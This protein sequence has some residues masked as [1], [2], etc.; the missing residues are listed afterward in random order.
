MASATAAPEPQTFDEWYVRSAYQDFVRQ[1]G[2]PLY[3]GSAIA[4][5]ASIELAPWQRRGG[6]VAY[7][8]LGEQEQRNLQIVEIPP[9][10]SLQPEHHMYD[11]VMYVM[12]GRG[13]TNIW[14]EGEPKR[15]IEWQEGS[16][17][18]LPL[19]AWHQEFNGSGSEPCRFLIASNMAY[20]INLYNNLEFVFNTPFQFKDRYSYDMEQY[21]AR[22]KKW[23]FRTLESNFIPD[24]RTMELDPYLERGRRTSVVRISMAAT[25]IGMHVME[26]GEGTYVTA[27]RHD[28]QAHVIVIGGEGYELMFMEGEEPRKV[29]AKPY[30]VVA[31]RHNEFHQH[32]NSGH[33]GYRML[34]FRGMGLRYGWGRKHELARG[35]QS[36][37]RNAVLYNIPAD[38]EDPAIREDYY[39]ELEKKGIS[40]RLEPLSQSSRG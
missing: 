21:A 40:L 1:E 11:A 7:T 36:T 8:R 3:E 16:L 22:N 30:A 18:A 4:D 26:A 9:G 19:N 37:D 27:H 12:R 34:A 29:W 15:T 5:L 6:L 13:A 23:D 38:Q 20:V 24:I 17:M 28:A 31:P 39:R 25:S 14:Q 10:E 33:G 35:A 32:F 2:A